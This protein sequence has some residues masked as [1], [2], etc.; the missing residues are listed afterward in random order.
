ML[1][2]AGEVVVHIPPSKLG[3]PAPRKR[4][5]ELLCTQ[6]VPAHGSGFNALL[7]SQISVAL[8]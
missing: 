7:Q 4:L 1:P 2:Q 5:N 8:P 3:Q 6:H